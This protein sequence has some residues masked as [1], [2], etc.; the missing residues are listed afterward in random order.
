MQAWR[1][2]LSPHL[3]IHSFCILQTHLLAKILLMGFLSLNFF[4]QPFQANASLSQ[5]HN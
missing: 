4:I 3:T 1:L 5:G 2:E